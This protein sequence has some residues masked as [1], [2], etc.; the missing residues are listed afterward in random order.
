LGLKPSTGIQPAKDIKMKLTVQHHNLRSSDE[1]DSLLEDRI[2]EL[3]PRLQIDEARVTL[4]CRW[5]QS[6]AYRVA[7]HIVTPGPDV[8]AEGQDH[9]IHAAISKALGHLEHRLRHREQ[10]PHQRLRSNLQM[11]SASRPGRARR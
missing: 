9:T 5:Q 7:I 8:Q 3:E 10:K 11:R 1:V 2:L 6:P 4:E